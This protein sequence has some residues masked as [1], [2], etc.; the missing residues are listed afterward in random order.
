MPVL[1]A[2]P[3]TV[4]HCASVPVKAGRE[5]EVSSGTWSN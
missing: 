2:D 1:P 3:Q 5:E 4:P